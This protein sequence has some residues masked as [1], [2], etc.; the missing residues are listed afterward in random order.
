[1]SMNQNDWEEPLKKVLLR[2]LNLAGYHETTLFL[3]GSRA[4]GDAST[5][6]DIDIG[7]KGEASLPFSF[8]AHLKEKVDKLN[9]PYKIDIVDFHWVSKEFYEHAMEGAIPWKN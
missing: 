9:L 1:M 5:V 2:E 7:I 4:V 8:I 6:S 3:F